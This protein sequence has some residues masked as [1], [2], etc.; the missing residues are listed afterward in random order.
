MVCCTKEGHR[1]KQLSLD[2]LLDYMDS[3]TQEKTFEIS[4]FAESFMEMLQ[5]YYG[6]MV[7]NALKRY[8][9]APEEPAPTGKRPLESA[10]TTESEAKKPKI[11]AQGEGEGEGEAKI[12]AEGQ[13][14]GTGVAVATESKGEEPTDTAAA[15][16]PSREES[17]QP[18]E[19]EK[20]PAAAPAKERS[21][22]ISD[23]LLT[24]FRFFDRYEAGFLKSRDLGDI[25]EYVNQETS[26]KLIMELTDR[27]C[28]DGNK[29]HYEH[30]DI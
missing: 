6:E 10:S 15:E 12:E 24:A 18:P 4:L 28:T 14:E 17:A 19:G 29:I 2:G 16:V 23:Q 26:G 21:K 8:H 30:L 27:L 20:K 25:F 7:F 3:D 5:A 1:T 11:E 22:R 13:G 9:P